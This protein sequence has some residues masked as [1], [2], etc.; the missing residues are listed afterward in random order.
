[1]ISYVRTLLG[2]VIDQESSYSASVVG[3]SDRTVSLLSSCVPDLRLDGLPINLQ[4]P[5]L[6]R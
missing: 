4:I 6:L 2:D 3:A 1:M 5:G